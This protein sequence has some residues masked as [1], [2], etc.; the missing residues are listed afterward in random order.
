GQQDFA[1][2]GSPPQGEST[3]RQVSRARCFRRGRFV[4]FDIEANAFLYRMVRSIVGTL[5]AVGVG[6]LSVADFAAILHACERSLA[7]APVPA[8]GLCLMRVC[9]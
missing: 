2:F 7:K 9:Y 6:E 5:L 1:S 8:H 3:V 4:C